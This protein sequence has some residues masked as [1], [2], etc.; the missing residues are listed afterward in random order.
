MHAVQKFRKRGRGWGGGRN[1]P[2]PP[3]CKPS[4][5]DFVFF[6]FAPSS[7]SPSCVLEKKLILIYPFYKGDSLSLT[8]FSCFFTPQRIRLAFAF[9]SVGED[10]SFMSIYFFVVNPLKR[11]RL[12]FSFL[13]VG[14]DVFI[15]FFTAQESGG[16]GG[17]AQLPSPNLQRRGPFEE[18]FEGDF[19]R[20][21][22]LRGGEDIFIVL[23]II[24][25][26]AIIIVIVIIQKQ[27]VKAEQR[28][29]R[30]AQKLKSNRKAKAEE[31]NQQEKNNKQSKQGRAASEN[32]NRE[33]RSRQSEKQKSRKAREAEK[34]EIREAEKQKSR[35]TEKQRK[36]KAEESK[37]TKSIKKRA[38]TY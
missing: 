16:V 35:Q 31:S 37:N 17:G 38:K 28:R 23:I 7:E 20:D 9:L 10:V 21:F 2:A 12:A 22:L 36:A 25:V 33:N 19:A 14:E 27:S 13:C 8:L 26:I 1:L 4:L 15:H 32:L 3:I 18:G 6:A 29:S 11:F 34:R 24:I 30:E 5:N